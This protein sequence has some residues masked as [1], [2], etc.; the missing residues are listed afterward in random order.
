MANMQKQRMKLPSFIIDPELSRIFSEQMPDFLIK[1]SGNIDFDWSDVCFFDDYTLLKL[2]FIQRQ[3]RLLGC[4]VSNKGFTFVH[5]DANKQAVLRQLWAVG[6]PELTASGHLIGSERL[7]DVLKDDAKL[8]E[9]DPLRGLQLPAPATAVIPMLCCHD[10]KHFATGS[11]EEKQLDSFVRACLRPSGPNSS[12]NLVES[13]EFRHLMLQQLRRNVQEHSRPDGRAAIG[14]AIVRVWTTQSLSDEWK[15]AENLQAQLLHLWNNAPTPS[16]LEKLGSDRGILQIS[17]IDD[18]KGIPRGLETVHDDLLLKAE[19]REIFERPHY[20]DTDFDS[21]FAEPASWTNKNAKLIAFAMDLLGT[22]K[23]DRAPEIKGLQYVRECAVIDMG[24]AV[25]IESHGAV[26]SHITRDRCYGQPCELDLAWCNTGGTGVCL[27][28]P[29]SPIKVSIDSQKLI[30]Q[31]PE[32]RGTAYTGSGVEPFKIRNRLPPLPTGSFYK[33]NDLVAC[34]KEILAAIKMRKAEDDVTK[35]RRKGLLVFDWGE[36]RESKRVFHSL[37]VEIAKGLAVTDTQQMRPFVFANLPKGLCGLLGSAISMYSRLENA[38]PI[39]A[40][41]AEHREPFW[42]GVDGDNTLSE[43]LRK[44]VSIEIQRKITDEKE[45]RT[46]AFHRDCIKQILSL[47]NLKPVSLFDTFVRRSVRYEDRLAIHQSPAYSRLDA[48]VRRCA[49]FRK[50]EQRAPDGEMSSEGGFLSVFSLE[51]IE[52]EVRTLFLNEFRD[53]FTSPPVCFTPPNKNDGIRLPHSKRVIKRYFRSDALVDSPI[54]IELTQEL[55]SIAFGIAKQVPCGRI[56]WVVTC[57]SPLHWF[58]HKIVD[59][60]AEHDMIC[61]HHVFT[62]YEEIPVLIEDIGMHSGETVLAFTDVIASGQTAYQIADS[63]VNHFGVKMV[64]L[65]A[66]ADIR[67]AEDRKNGPD[68]DKAYGGTIVCLYNEQEPHCQDLK[69]T[70]YVHPETVVPKRVTSSNPKDEF[71]EKNYSGTGPLVENHGY[72]SSAKRTLDLMTLLRAVHFGHYQHGSHH[73]E[74]FVDVEKVLSCVEYRYIMVTALFSYIVTHDIRLV[75]YPN[76]S[77]AYMLADELKQR[78]I[79]DDSSVEFIMACRTYIGRG[80]RGTSYALTRFSPHPDPLQWKNFSSNAVLI[81]DDAVCSGTTVESIMAELVRIDRNYYDTQPSPLPY[82]SE[83][84]FSIHVVAFLNR[85]PRVT[86]DFWKGLSRVAAGRIQFSTFISMPL[87]ADSEELC[88]QCLLEKKLGEESNSATYCL[89]AKEFLSWWISCSKVVSSH[90][91][92]HFDNQQRERFSSEEA[93][94]L[95][96]YLSAI[97]RKAYNDVRGDLFDKQGIPGEEK[98]KAVRVFVRSRAGFLHDLFP[99]TENSSDLI[100]DLCVEI[101]NLISM[102]LDENGCL[103]SRLGIDDALEILQVLTQRYLRMRPTQDEVERVFGCLLMKLAKL[104]DN[105]LVVGGVAAVLD[106][107]LIWFMLPNRTESEWRDIRL[108]LKDK[109]CKI[110]RENLPSKAA[111]MID[112]FDTYLSEGEKRIKSV[113]EAVRMLAEFAKKGRRNHFYGRHEV[114][115]LVEIY[116]RPPSEACAD[117]ATENIRRTLACTDLFS[118]LVKATRVLQSASTMEETSLKELQNETERDILELRGLCNNLKS[119]HGENILK[120]YVDIKSLFLRTYY[121][122]FPT[123]EL[124]RAKAVDIIGNF[125]PNLCETLVNASERY[126]PQRRSKE[127]F[128]I[129]IDELSRYSYVKVLIDPTV[130]TTAMNQLLDNVDKL[131]EQ[132]T[133]V[134]VMCRI[135]LPDDNNEVPEGTPRIAFGQVGVVVSNTGT[136]RPKIAQLKPRGL[137]AVKIR[138]SEYGGGLDFVVPEAQWSFEVT[139]KL[140]VWTEEEK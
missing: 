50:V 64:G 73:S 16:I 59:G 12:W 124:E 113:G 6:L 45:N 14:L 130:L 109:A 106:S 36:L 49:L 31:S 79:V 123:G 48:L 35:L 90:E 58:V 37:L 87:T 101:G 13:R 53:I 52:A 118:D 77:S 65:I 1:E 93:L 82:I 75:L 43:E 137:S 47:S 70:Y 62:S 105:R 91:R 66:L 41:T 138:L 61:S 8:L 112:W 108:S 107:C 115:E 20:S 55:T 39:C 44:K 19:Q 38:T 46:E 92:R 99:R 81:L 104:F 34:A 121:R 15:L 94:R 83:S 128:A 30:P 103:Y 136:P 133:P 54:A 80:T 22:S 84:R 28:V 18:G 60:L 9:S 67:T 42:L 139:M 17:V 32:Y 69:P 2:I 111:V 126:S 125:T 95:A 132:D 100:G 122:W 86:G 4:R 51:E 129:N 102:I 127:A 120:N 21:R 63:L 26:I 76:H 114:D 56:D 40:F 85:L 140:P 23:T 10:R 29:M 98:S 74:V 89:Y 24:G 25:C 96:G 78:F 110:D 7:K 11:R 33:P 71:F 5:S 88:P 97:E 135:S 119:E 116:S 68:L 134:S 3:L 131:A 27:A 57:T 117:D 72:F